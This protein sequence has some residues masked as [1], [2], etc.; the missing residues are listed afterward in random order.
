MFEFGWGHAA[1]IVAAVLFSLAI[2]FSAATRSAKIAMYTGSICAV[3]GALVGYP[4]VGL[5]LLLAGLAGFVVI[6]AVTWGTH[7]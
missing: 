3:I 4:F 2:Y 7:S 6:Q 1:L 5:V